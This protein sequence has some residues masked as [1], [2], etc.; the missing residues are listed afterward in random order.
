MISISLISPSNKK[1]KKGCFSGKI[2]VAQGALK[3]LFCG[4]AKPALGLMNE[5]EKSKIL[6]GEHQQEPHL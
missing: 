5:H 6:K 2:L 4:E 1:G 3:I